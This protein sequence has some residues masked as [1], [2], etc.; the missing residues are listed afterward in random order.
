MDYGYDY[1]LDTGYDYS[2]GYDYELDNG[3]DYSY[4]YSIV[5]IVM[6]LAT[7]MDY[8]GYGLWL[9]LWL[10]LLVTYMDTLFDIV[11]VMIMAI[12]YGY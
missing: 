12:D 9:L 8:Y 1:E 3:Y 6:N 4:G 5:I 7:V 2:Y 11:K 10:S